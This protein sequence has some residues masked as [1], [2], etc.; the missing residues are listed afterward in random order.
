[1]AQ[2]DL[3]V[4]GRK[5]E[6]GCRDGGEARLMT[7]AAMIDAKMDDAKRAV[8]RGSEGREL[9]FAALLLADELDEARG[10]IATAEAEADASAAEVERFASRLE[11]LV[12]GLEKAA[13]SA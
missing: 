3:D 6:V 1:M 10:R 11:A 9:L 7:L 13:D 8:G 2:I 5:Y 12:D 4:G